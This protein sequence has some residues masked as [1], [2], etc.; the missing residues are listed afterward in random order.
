MSYDLNFWRYKSRIR[1]VHKT[2]YEQLSAGQ[3]VDGL[4]DLPI[5]DII[6]RVKET[7]SDWEK[8][9]ERTFDGGE[10]GGFDIFTTPQS[11]RVDCR[12]LSDDE[13]NAFIDIG[14]EFGCPLY[15]PQAGQR[16]ETQ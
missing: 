1:L 10:R 7:F 15:D 9:N 5:E 6:R 8:L 16:Y 4:E 13:M 2:V 12:G 3:H 14:S 11:F